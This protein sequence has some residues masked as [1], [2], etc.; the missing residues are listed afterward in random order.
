[1]TDAAAQGISAQ[2]VP[3][4]SPSTEVAYFG[5]VGGLTVVLGVAL[6]FLA[7]VVQRA[8]RGVH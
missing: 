6:Y 8:M 4:F 2:I 1:M 5:I 7:P 3:V